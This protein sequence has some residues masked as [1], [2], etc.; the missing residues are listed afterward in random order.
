L[1]LSLTLSILPLISFLFIPQFQKVVGAFGWRSGYLLLAA[2]VV[3]VCL[4]VMLLT[5]R[6]RRAETA[7]SK[8]NAKAPAALSGHDNKT[9][10]RTSAFWLIVGAMVLV[11]IPGGGILLHMGPMITD[12]GFNAAQAAQLI[13]VYPLAMIIGRLVSGVFLDSAPYA[14]A[15]LATVLPAFGYLIFL[16]GGGSM[17]FYA[18]A[19]GIALLGVQQGAELDLLSFFL[20]R[21]MGLRSYGFFFGLANMMNAMAIA[22]GTFYFGWAYDV[23]GT[24]NPVLLTAAITFP[25][26]ALCFFVLRWRPVFQ[27]EAAEAAPVAG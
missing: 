7:D 4:P 22:A 21:H 20:A 26:G 9:G 13:A 24:Y 14:V 11:N 17:G 12:H 25:L 18:A 6:V 8:G 3:F 23:T 1:A 15:A 5:L 19:A 16:L 10:L 2:M 27:Q